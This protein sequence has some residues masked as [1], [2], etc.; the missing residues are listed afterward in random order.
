MPITSLPTEI[1]LLVAEN[2]GTLAN[3][4]ALLRTNR[5]MHDILHR[6]IFRLALSRTATGAC[7]SIE[8]LQ[9]PITLLQWIILNGLER[10][11]RRAI[12]ELHAGLPPWAMGHLLEYAL[13]NRREWLLPV[14]LEH[15]HQHPC[16]QAAQA[17][18][19]QTADAGAGRAAKCPPLSLALRR[20]CGGLIT[21]V[22]ADFEPPHRARALAP[23]AI[24]TA[25]VVR[26][27][28]A[29]G[30]DAEAR[31]DG[32]TP[33]HYAAWTGMTDVVRVLL[34][35][36]VHVD[37]PLDAAQGGHTALHIAAG[38]GFCAIAAD[39]V[40]HGADPRRRSTHGTALEC[41]LRFRIAAAPHAPPTAADVQLAALLN[42]RPP[43]LCPPPPV[44]SGAGNKDEPGPPRALPQ[45]R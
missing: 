12:H 43:A 24:G 7:A 10:P 20:A 29:H 31:E 41:F 6:R 27:L 28:L 25:A 44:V 13:N 45:E 11:L 17:A 5:R 1:V 35:H 3:I 36:G 34:A 4:N 39:L 9:S 22:D 16:A 14:L 23:L 21:P 33:L 2:L 42:P 37:A 8:L 30:A 15:Q 40:A 19:A 32:L 18:Q 38:N 26:L